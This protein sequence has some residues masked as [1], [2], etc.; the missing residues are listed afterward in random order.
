MTNIFYYFSF[1]WE[2]KLLEKAIR[3]EI[4]AQQYME[5]IDAAMEEIKGTVIL[6]DS[7]WIHRHVSKGS[8]F[9]NFL[10]AFL[11]NLALP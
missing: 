5:K 1:D 3:T 8:N 11:D 2:D 7:V 9:R 4:K 6:S 10:L